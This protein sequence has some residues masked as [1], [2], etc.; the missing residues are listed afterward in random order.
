[1]FLRSWTARDDEK[2]CGA[3]LRE[4]FRQFVQER[5]LRRNQLLHRDSERKP[6]SAVDFGKGLHLAGSWRLFHLETQAFEGREVEI[7]FEGPGINNLSAL[8]AHRV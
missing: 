8:L 7:A 5:A 2:L 3:V 4:A 1:M 6:A